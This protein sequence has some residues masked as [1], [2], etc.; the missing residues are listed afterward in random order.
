MKPLVDAGWLALAAG[1]DA[2]S[3]S[4][5]ITPTGRAKQEEAQRHW[6][7]AQESLNKLLGSARVLSLHGLINESLELLPPAQTDTGAND[8]DDE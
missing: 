4:V 2:R 6:K 8:D 1:S 7:V 3:R 5:A